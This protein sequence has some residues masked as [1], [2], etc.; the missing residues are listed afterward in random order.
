MRKLLKTTALCSLILILSACS[1][2]NME[3]YEKLKMGMD[4]AE[5]ES[6][7]GGA[8]KCEESLGSESCI[9]G[10]ESG[11][12]VKINFVGGKAVLFSHDGLE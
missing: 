1:R 10:S 2:L 4:K 9:W 7:I 5:V 3:N 8:S 6:I 12:F 11:K